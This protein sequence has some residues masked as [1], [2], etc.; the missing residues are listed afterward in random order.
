MSN[1]YFKANTDNILNAIEGLK[2]NFIVHSTDTLNSLSADATN[3]RCIQKVI[4]FKNR[5]GPFSIILNSIEQ[6]DKYTEVNKEQLKI[7]KKLLPGPFT[8]LLKSKDSNLSKLVTEDSDLVGIRIPN[9]NFTLNLIEKFKSPIITT[10]LNKTGEKPIS[11]LKKVAK[12]YTDILIFDD[13]QV[14]V[15][16]GSTILDISKNEIKIVRYGDGE[17]NLW[18]LTL[19]Y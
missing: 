3:D 7:V 13:E 11:N 2:Q 10:S 15:S 17:Y 4:D 9:H 8:I 16:K 19:K 12:V 18:N 14:R 1:L 6:I 5:R